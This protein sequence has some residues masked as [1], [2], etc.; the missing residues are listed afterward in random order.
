MAS[1]DSFIPVL[2]ANEGGYQKIPSDSGNYNSMSELVGT[3][4][5]ISAPVYEQWIGRPPSETDMVNM[6]K[7]TAI[8]IHKILFWDKL[9]LDLVISQ[10][11]SE[12]LADHA[13]NAGNGAAVKIMQR[14]LNRFFNENLSVDGGLGPLTLAAINKV[15]PD[16]L[17]DFYNQ[18]RA[19]WYI[20]LS[21]PQFLGS[22]IGR[23]NNLVQKFGGKIVSTL[24]KKAY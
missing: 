12:T 22:W 6:S 15:N 11:V 21:M 17:F 1:F 14:T 23:I 20:S 16:A 19:D 9:N 4:W 10:K 8:Q 2:M 5:G 7:D 13:I 18:M 24:K 3:N